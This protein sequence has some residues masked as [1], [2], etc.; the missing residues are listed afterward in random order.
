M[1]NLACTYARL[2]QK[3]KAFD[4][5]FKALDAGFDETWTMRFDEDL[6][7]LR[8]DSR[9]RKAVDIAKGRSDWSN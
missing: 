5:L 3:D 9:Y 1:Y 7:N 4:W 2:E 6:D 8:G